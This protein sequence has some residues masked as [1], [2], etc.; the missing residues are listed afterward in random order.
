MCRP[1]SDMPLTSS[2]RSHVPKKSRRRWIM[3]VEQV[4]VARLHHRADEYDPD[5]RHR[6]E[7][8]PAESHDLVVAI[9]G[10]RRAH[11][12][13]NEQHRRHLESEPHESIAERMDTEDLG[14]VENR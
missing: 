3:S 7:H 11:P 12:E 8:L 5:E 9:A 6:N 1:V 13:E 4:C 2:I 10:K 14:M